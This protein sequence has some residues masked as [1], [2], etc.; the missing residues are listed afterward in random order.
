MSDPSLARD[1][2]RFDTSRAPRILKRSGLTAVRSITNYTHL[3]VTPRLPSGA[4]SA[5]TQRLFQVRR[6]N[7]KSERGRCVYYLPS[8]QEGYIYR[9]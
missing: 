7:F 9:G 2:L 4:G 3:L 5:L 8:D 6:L 1:V